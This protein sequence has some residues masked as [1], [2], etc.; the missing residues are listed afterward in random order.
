MKGLAVY[1]PLFNQLTCEFTVHTPVGDVTFT[2][3]AGLLCSGTLCDVLN[4]KYP[5]WITCDWNI[6]SYGWKDTL[7]FEAVRPLK[8]AQA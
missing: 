7:R 1:P 3:S 4:D 8:C 6:K 2:K 5:G